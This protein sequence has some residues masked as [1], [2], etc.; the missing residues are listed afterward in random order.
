V[1]S[2][3]ETF[4]V[5]LN[6]DGDLVGVVAT[7]ASSELGTGE[8]LAA[9]G[10][11]AEATL[12][13]AFTL[14][15]PVF[16]VTPLGPLGCLAIDWALVTVASLH[17]DNGRAHLATRLRLGCNRAGRSLESS[18]TTRDAALC[19]GGPLSYLAVN[20]AVHVSASLVLG[21]GGTFI[22]TELGL[23]QNG[24]MSRL[25]ACA[26]GFG[27]S[28]PRRPFRYGAVHRAGREL[29]ILGV[30]RLAAASSETSFVVDGAG[31]G[32]G[33]GNTASSRACAETGPLGHS[34]VKGASEVVALLHRNLGETAAKFA[35]MVGSLDH[36]SSAVASGGNTVEVI[37]IVASPG[38]SGP[39]GPSRD[40]AVN[41]TNLAVASLFVD[42][43]RASIS[44]VSS[45]LDD[46]PGALVRTTTTGLGA[47]GPSR[48][49]AD[50]AVDRAWLGDA[51]S[52]IVQSTASPAI[53]S[54][55]LDDPGAL[56]TAATTGDS[57][58]SPRTPS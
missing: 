1:D 27:T 48:P 10:L 13:G 15:G 55:G 47:F 38:A 57:A 50:R 7:L 9:T 39:S 44:S 35:A 42:Q 24:T 25:S 6:L 49:G 32:F 5:L 51:S 21:I 56:H 2:T 31:T 11:L 3:L 34:T 12:V 33:D 46:L 54:G 28:G 58:Y 43:S 14:V 16:E 22:A 8:A 37:A 53:G 29:A 23:G 19:E 52:L 40:L 41:S 4:A 36:R 17:L 26:A 20:G 30:F 45:V 18:L